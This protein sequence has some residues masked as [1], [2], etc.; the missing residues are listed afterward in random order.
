MLSLAIDTA[1]AFSSAGGGL[2][3]SVVCSNDCSSGHVGLHDLGDYFTL[4]F[5]VAGRR[6]G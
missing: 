3:S 2:L 4:A 1:S 6:G 5:S